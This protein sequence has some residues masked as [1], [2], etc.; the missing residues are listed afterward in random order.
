MIKLKGEGIKAII[1]S[2][3]ALILVSISLIFFYN[4][5]IE[6]QELQFNS[7][8]KK[9]NNQLADDF[10]L[11][12]SDISN[13][14]DNLTTEIQLVDT[15]LNSV[16]EQNEEDL[17]TINSL[18]EEIEKQ[19]K[20]SLT[21]LKDELKNIRIR[22]KD[23]TSVIDEVLPS[24]V[25]VATNKGLG[26]GAVVMENGFIVTNYHV[27]E[28]AS[29][30]KIHTYAGKIY[31]ATLIGFEPTFDIAVLKV[32][33]DLPVIQ[34]GDSERVRVGE[35]VI[36]LGNPAGLSFTVTEGIVSA[37]KRVGPNGLKIYIQTDVPI[38]PGNSGGPLVDLNSKIIGINNFKV[39]NFE[40]L[41][42]AIESN[43]VLEIVQEIISQYNSK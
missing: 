36:A 10:A 15:S 30:I 14:R 8:I 18:I 27:V 34:F 26:S 17:R 12:K 32:D 6:K 31:P 43:T 39:G 1:V 25:S 42:F 4:D 5:K 7:E 13:T 3:L 2:I 35:K 28:R 41:G 11:L 37:A 9:L 24:V 19:S 22:S 29:L 33:S 40:G 16:K 20:I 38:N 21:E 23:F